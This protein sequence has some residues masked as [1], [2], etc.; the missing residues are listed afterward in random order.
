[1]QLGIS[2]QK[3]FQCFQDLATLSLRKQ[4]DV[5]LKGKPEQNPDLTFFAGFATVVS[6]YEATT[7][8]AAVIIHLERFQYSSVQFGNVR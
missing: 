5:S 6:R 8:T 3:H 7:S 1:M 2:M 4:V